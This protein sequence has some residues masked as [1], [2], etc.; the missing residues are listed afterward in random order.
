MKKILA[1]FIAMTICISLASCGDSDKDKDEGGNKTGSTAAGISEEDTASEEDKDKEE[2]DE[3]SEAEDKEE[4]EKEQEKSDKKNDDKKDKEDKKED[5][6]ADKLNGGY[7]NDVYS[8]SFDPDK[9]MDAI[10][11]KEFIAAQA[12]SEIGSFDINTMLDG[13]YY[14]TDDVNSNYPTNILFVA[15]TY[16]PSVGSMNITDEGVADL[17]IQMVEMQMNATDGINVT[18]SSIVNR[19]GNDWL[20]IQVHADMNGIVYDCDEYVLFHNGYSIVISINY[21]DASSPAKAD[22]ERMI[23]NIEFK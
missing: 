2:K 12:G 18:G 6:P 23:D 10:E 9:W 15:P 21:S 7:S 3:Q 5:K 16:D 19:G 20:L 1:A 17:M 11:F 4:E 22:F 14:Y 13:I 8:I